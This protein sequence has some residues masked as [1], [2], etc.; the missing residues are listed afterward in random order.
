MPELVRLYIRHVFIGLLLGAAFTALLLWLNVANLWH[1]V[2]ATREGPLAVVMLVVFNT[3]V[4]SGVQFAYA[5]MQ[6]AEKPG[7]GGGTRAP[8]VA[9]EPA[10]VTVRQTSGG[11]RSDRAGVNF[12][13]A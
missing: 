2:T 9:P 5:V 4:F 3:I 12:P 10:P 1:L 11:N 8:A 6:M 13:R 7:R